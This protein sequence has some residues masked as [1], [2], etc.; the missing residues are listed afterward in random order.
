MV[1]HAYARV[2][3]ACLY[4]YSM[5]V[6]EYIT[7]QGMRTRALYAHVTHAHAYARVIGACFGRADARVAMPMRQLRVRGCACEGMRTRGFCMRE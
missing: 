1:M 2:I 6:V 5:Y 4:Q 7:N 3:G